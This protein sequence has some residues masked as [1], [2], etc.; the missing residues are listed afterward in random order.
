MIAFRYLVVTLLVAFCLARSARAEALERMNLER[1][2]ATHERVE[3]LATQRVPVELK[4]G[5]DDVRVLLHVHSAF[6][7]DSRGTI[8]EIVKAAKTVGVRAILFTEHPADHYD[9]IKDG[10]QGM[11]DGVLLIPGAESG[12]FLA[13]PT[14]SLK[15]EKTGDKQEFADLVKQED[16]MI[17]L[18]HL[19][20]RMDWEIAGLTGTEIYNT[21]ADFK[22]ELKFA[23]ALKNPLALLSLSQAV[24]L[25]PQEMFAAL[26]DY[27]AD[28]LKRWDDLCQKSRHTGVSANDSHH[29]QAYRARVTE[30]G[31]IDLIDAL[32]KKITTLDPD[33]IP[34]FKASV[35]GKKVGDLVFEL[36]LDPYERSFRHVSTHLLLKELTRENIWDALKASRAYVS[37]DWMA[38]PTGFVYL[39][40]RAEKVNG[41]AQS[42]P[43]GGEVPAGEK[44]RLRAAAP[45]AGTIKLLRNGK[46]IEQ[47][48]GATLDKTVEEPGV[49]RVE[50]WLN[51]AG[52]PRPWILSNPI[53]VKGK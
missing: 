49:Y 6:S 21:H 16:G 22:D 14:R 10:H 12:G 46:V 33:K 20:E 11:T 45:L 34:L 32:D 13:Y 44:V 35:K 9:Y 47:V 43:I 51:L 42:W 28:Y 1:L 31:K 41:E 2:R 26:Q 15:G 19:E 27:P 37:F 53:Y 50:V 24:K 48:E 7:H 38:D 40:D 3:Q 5:Y 29:N 36:D 23:T 17:F 30:E 18:S 8:E 39:A 4:S 52:E 25:Y